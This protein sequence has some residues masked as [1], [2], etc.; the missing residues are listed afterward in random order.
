LM[1]TGF[2][3]ASVD[4]FRFVAIYESD[5]LNTTAYLRMNASR[6]THTVVVARGPKD[7]EM[8]VL[9]TIPYRPFS[10]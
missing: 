9:Q 2:S 1:C 10:L 7:A 6:G 5:R 4:F 8:H 3:E